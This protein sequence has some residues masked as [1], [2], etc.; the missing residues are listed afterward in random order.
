MKKI[1]LL[2]MISLP[3]QSI[4]GGPDHAQ[5]GVS[6]SGEYSDLDLAIDGAFPDADS[7]V[8]MGLGINACFPLGSVESL[9]FFWNLGFSMVTRSS[10]KYRLGARLGAF[11]RGRIY[12]FA[13][14]HVT[15]WRLWHNRNNLES[16]MIASSDANEHL[17]FQGGAGVIVHENEDYLIVLEA[18]YHQ[19][20]GNIRRGNIDI[21]S[22]A[23]FIN[24]GFY[25]DLF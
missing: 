18:G 12:L 3:I 5:I 19:D 16:A 9:D 17:S 23:P 24:L 10:S 6:L 7:R 8:K 14:V 21:T 2:A 15:F 25:T 22:H 1:L 11:P 13:G 20:K 4:A